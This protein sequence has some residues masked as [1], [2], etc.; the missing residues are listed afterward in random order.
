MMNPREMENIRERKREERKG[1]KEGRG[2][3]EVEERLM[4]P[5]VARIQSP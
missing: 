2:W 4:L 5:I 1:N 3:G